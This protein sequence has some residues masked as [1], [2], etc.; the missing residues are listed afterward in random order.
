MGPALV[1]DITVPGHANYLAH[2]LWHHNSG[3]TAVGI[4]AFTELHARG[5]ARK[6]FY[7][8]PSVV[9]AQAGEEMAR[10]VK[11]G[12]YN[13]AAGEATFEERVQNYRNPGTHMVAVTHQAF[14]DDMV[15]LMATA[16]GYDAPDEAADAFLAASPK[17]RRAMLKKALDEHEIP[18]DFLMMDEAHDALDRTG[19]A[20]S[21]LTA[22]TQ[23]A[24]D[25][26]QY[27]L[28]A[29][30][31]PIKNDAS[32]VHSWLQKLDPERFGDRDEFMRKY[33]TDAH[34]SSEALKRLM[35]RYA[36]VD[37]VPS[38][39]SR[40]ITWGAQDGG[41]RESPSGHQRIALTPAQRTSLA[42]VQD[43]YERA[44]R[45]RQN[46]SV[47]ADALRVLSPRSFEGRSPERQQE[48][49][50]RLNGALGALRHAAEA[51]VV[52]EA[53]VAENAKA[54]HVLR[55]AGEYKGK[56]G[57]VFAHNRES[58]RMLER[59]LEEAGHKVA[60]ITGSDNAQDKARARE[61]FKR[62]EVDILVASDAAATGANFQHRGEWLVNYDLP[63]THKT[64]EQRNAR[65]D[66]LGQTRH[67]Q[68]H[69]LITDA[70]HDHDNYERLERKRAL[71]SI[72]QGEH[73][74][75]D[76]TGIAKYL[77]VAREGKPAPAPAPDEEQGGMFA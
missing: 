70:D 63:L 33:G 57:V 47:D 43:A 49:A 37:V 46:G 55:L 72:L 36:Y 60:V 5:K 11:P 25:L 7:V 48:V 61:R 75:L 44:R 34:A 41:G 17:E 35:A 1:Y 71:G 73:E 20:E 23:A 62:G 56:G 39:A 18:L 2:G 51:R 26:S 65:I 30:G 66:R 64:L 76:D 69:H 12:E 15:R 40:T 28:L 21:L 13:W 22:V 38:G 14:R 53:P 9:R 24:G 74:S 52:N 32:E 45:A 77:A 8:V 3:K 16:H 67:I 68:L 42:H 6:G 58:V 29:T 59:A 54:Q 27:A 50:K 10:L 4:G 19:K 31:T